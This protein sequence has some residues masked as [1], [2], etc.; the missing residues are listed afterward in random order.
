MCIA[1]LKQI[2]SL[3]R[4]SLKKRTKIVFLN[5]MQLIWDIYFSDMGIKTV[6][7]AQ[8]FIMLKF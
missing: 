5:E 2:L 8:E 6:L 1:Y 3:Y 7:K 4:H